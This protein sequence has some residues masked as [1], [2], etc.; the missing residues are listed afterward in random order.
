MRK[1][2]AAANWK[3]NGRK[4]D[5]EKF[6]QG[7]NI[8]TRGEIVFAPPAAY[9]SFAQAK[10]TGNFALSAQTASEHADGA[11]TGEL[12]MPM[13]DDIGCQYVIVGHSERR[14]R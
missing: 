6:A 7:L 14:A 5:V 2:I 1:M 11:F 4:A 8:D 13:L 12:S 10:N 3:M 9:L